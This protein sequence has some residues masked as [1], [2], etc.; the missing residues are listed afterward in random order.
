VRALPA[1]E[2]T[3]TLVLFG[4]SDAD[5][6]RTMTTALTSACDVSGAAHLPAGLALTS[7]VP[8]LA[9]A[10]CSATLL[11]LEGTRT[12]VAARVLHLSRL[13]LKLAT[14]SVVDANDSVVAWRDIRDASFFAAHPEHQVWRLSVPP[15]AG[16]EVVAQILDRQP[17]HVFYDWAG[18]LIWLALQPSAEAGEAI[19][20]GAVGVKGGHAT[21]LRAAP[22]V[23]AQV[24]VFQ[25]QPPP[26]AALTRRIKEA[27][28]PHRVLNPGR[29]Y[30]GV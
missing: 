6:V 29:L 4:L 23:R 11:R 17:G 8:A 16:A 24:P 12:S 3:R 10:G 21:L 30:A 15:S 26:L 20:R 9:S 5:G 1:P 7:R 14:P 28:D 2:E 27:F 22:E 25:P 18:G 13:L 19:V